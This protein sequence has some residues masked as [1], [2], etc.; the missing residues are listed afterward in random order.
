MFFQVVTSES[1][2]FWSPDRLKKLEEKRLV[3][4]SLY[5]GEGIRKQ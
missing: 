5:R 1:G 2:A 4:L 3:L